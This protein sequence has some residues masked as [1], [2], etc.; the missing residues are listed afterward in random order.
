MKENPHKIVNSII[1]GNEI[2]AYDQDMNM[3][4]NF[5]QDA[6]DQNKNAEMLWFCAYEKSKGNAPVNSTNKIDYR[7]QKYI[8]FGTYIPQL[9]AGKYYYLDSDNTTIKESEGNN[10]DAVSGLNPV[11]CNIIID[12][13]NDAINFWLSN[14]TNIL[15][16][17]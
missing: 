2:S 7:L 11:T 15:Q 14:L 9:W 1:W 6:N 8:G 17:K 16:T 10:P 4:V 13:E 12:S 5:A 3:V